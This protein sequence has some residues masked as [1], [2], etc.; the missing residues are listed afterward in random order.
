MEEASFGDFAAQV[1]RR[2][3]ALRIERGLTTVE[4]GRR[5]GVSHS[6]VARLEKGARQLTLEH[7]P[8]LARALN[9]T[10]QDLFAAATPAVRIELSPHGFPGLTMWPMSRTG[11][12]GLWPFKLAMATDYQ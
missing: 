3:R 9:V 8:Q 10:V 2:I 6:T 5:M 7:L 4:L 12:A 11:L 1:R